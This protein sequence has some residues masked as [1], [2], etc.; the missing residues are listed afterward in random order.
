MNIFWATVVIIMA[1]VVCM[2]AVEI[3]IRILG[4]GRK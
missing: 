3:A 2:L 4:G 1:Y